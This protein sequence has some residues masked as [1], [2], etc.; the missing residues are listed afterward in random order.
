MS[1]PPCHIPPNSANLIYLYSVDPNDILK[2]SPHFV[3][4]HVDFYSRSFFPPPL[5][6]WVLLLS[7][8]II[9]PPPHI[10]CENERVNCKPP[11]ICENERVELLKSIDLGIHNY[12]KKELWS[13][14]KLLKPI[15]LGIHN[16]LKKELWS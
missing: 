10:I 5:P 13:E 16:Y 3:P 1:A 2:K 12:L 11:I 7:S 8:S 9:G 14:Y 4:N 6:L 15:D